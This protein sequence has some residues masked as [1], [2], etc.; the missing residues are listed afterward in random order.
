[1]TPYR[2]CIDIPGLPPGNSAD[3]RGRWKKKKIRDEWSE[4]V[5]VT[6]HNKKP[7]KPL[8]RAG[9]LF[10]RFSSVAPDFGG[11]VEGFKI[12]LDQLVRSGVLVDDNPKVCAYDD[13]HYAWE[14]VPPREGKI[15]LEVWEVT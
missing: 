1:M 3:N 2:L 7:P 4:A 13:C 12:V 15:R 5:A 6:L 11:L 8:A 10:T 14:K 9:Y